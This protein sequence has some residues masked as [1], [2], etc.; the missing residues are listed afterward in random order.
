M[1]DSMN[2]ELEA[3][4]FD[5]LLEI[6]HLALDERMIDEAG[7]I[8]SVLTRARPSNPHPRIGQALIVYGQRK[9]DEAIFILEGILR[10]FPN[11]IFTRSLLAKIQ[12]EVGR[13]NWQHYA[14]EVLELADDGVAVEMARSLLGQHGEHGESVTRSNDAVAQHVVGRP[15]AQLGGASESQQH[16]YLR[17]A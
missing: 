11:A 2:I 5:H 12:Q 15:V 16:L 14:R 6:A 3:T 4:E 1:K 7:E 17:P 13:P 10:D 8:F 9:H